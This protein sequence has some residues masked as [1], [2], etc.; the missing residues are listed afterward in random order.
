MPGY[1]LS[2]FPANDTRPAQK[3]AAL[4]SVFGDDSDRLRRPPLLRTPFF[5]E[6]RTAELD[7]SPDRV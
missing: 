2:R 3:D 7:F 5:S 4:L 6:K 1:G